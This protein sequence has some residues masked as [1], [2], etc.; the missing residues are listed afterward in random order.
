MARKTLRPKSNIAVVGGGGL[1]DMMFTSRQPMKKKKKRK[2]KKLKENVEPRIFYHG[3]SEVNAKEIDKMGFLKS[4]QPGDDRTRVRQSTGGAGGTMDEEGLIWVTKDPE[5]AKYVDGGTADRIY[6]VLVDFPLKIMSRWQKLTKKQAEILNKVN[7]RG[8]YDPI[9][10][11][12]ELSIAVYKIFQHPDAPGTYAQLLPM[13]GKNA[14]EDETGI[15]IA[16]ESLP[17]GKSWKP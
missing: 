16:A 9:K 13:I 2:K 8:H 4:V 15:A 14:I 11:G 6:E 17:V 3:T 12:T 5:Q 1:M 10:E 7:L